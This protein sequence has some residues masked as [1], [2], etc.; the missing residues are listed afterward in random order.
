MTKEFQECLKNIDS[1]QGTLLQN[2]LDTFNEIVEHD[3]GYED[4]VNISN[5]QQLKATI[6]GR[7]KKSVQMVNSESFLNACL[8]CKAMRI[9]ALLKFIIATEHLKDEDIEA[10]LGESISDYKLDR[11]Y[12]ETFDQFVKDLKGN[13]SKFISSKPLRRQLILDNK[14][15]KFISTEKKA[16]E[17]AFPDNEKI[18][19]PTWITELSPEEL[20]DFGNKTV[21]LIKENN[22]KDFATFCEDK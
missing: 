17:E 21:Q 8:S 16:L 22:F 9:L 15:I 11:R 13:I 10:I 19:P 18:S 2:L 3:Q 5:V 7:L 6:L 20:L 1:L 12:T 14:V 4:L